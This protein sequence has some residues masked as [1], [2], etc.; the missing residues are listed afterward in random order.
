MRVQEKFCTLGQAKKLKELGVNTRPLCQW[1][2]PTM[3]GYPAY[4][5]FTQPANL[6]LPTH[7]PAYN[8]S[9]LGQM[10]PKSFNVAGFGETQLLIAK[11]DKWYVLYVDVATE[12]VPYA[13][14]RSDS[15]AESMAAMLIFLLEKKLATVMVMDEI[16]QRL[17]A[18][19]IFK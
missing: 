16:E 3:E 9:E 17:D 10:L 15:L 6:E 11:Y 13:K 18:N 19:G 5:E 8:A 1:Y 2:V 7:F 4:I 14:E 12:T